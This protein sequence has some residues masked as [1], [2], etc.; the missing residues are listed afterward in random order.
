MLFA[1]CV[2]SLLRCLFRSLVHF[3]TGLFVFLL[4]NVKCSLYILDNSSLSDVSVANIFSQSVACLFLLLTLSFAEQ[5]L[6]ILTKSSLLILSFMDCDFDFVP[7]KHAQTQCY[8]GFPV[9]FW[10]FYSFVFCI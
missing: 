5:K 8:L 7:K 1:V 3:L 6:L 9:I 2:S 4:L 10:E